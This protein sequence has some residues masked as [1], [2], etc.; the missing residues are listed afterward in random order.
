[1]RTA[2]V[3]QGQKTAVRKINLQARNKA[4]DKSV[5][6]SELPTTEEVLAPTYAETH[7]PYRTKQN[8]SPDS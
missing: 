4:V 5:D 7:L 8:A 2:G 3:C 1:M 6:M